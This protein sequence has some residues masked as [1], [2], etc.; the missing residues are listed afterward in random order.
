[1]IKRASGEEHLNLRLT[2]WELGICALV[3]LSGLPLVLLVVEGPW[4]LLLAVLQF[5]VISILSALLIRPKE[6]TLTTSHSYKVIDF[7]VIIT[8]L[9]MHLSVLFFDQT[10]LCCAISSIVVSFV[11]G[12]AIAR[13]L[14]FQW[15]YT[16]IEL[17]VVSYVVSI[18]FSSILTLILLP[19]IQTSILLGRSVITT[20]YLVLGLLPLVYEI[21]KQRPVYQ[22]EI[23]TKIIP[24]EVVALIVIV[25]FFTLSWASTY[26]QM[27]I[28]NSIVGSDV[29]RHLAATL[30]L[31]R[32]PEYYMS[33]YPFFHLY[34]ASLLVIANPSISDFHITLAFLG[35]INILAFFIMAKCYLNKYHK[36]LAAIATMLWVFAAGFGWLFVLAMYLLGVGSYQFILRLAFDY[37]YY[38]VFYGQGL[39]IWVWYRPTTIGFTM[40]FT[41]FYFMRRTDLSKWTSVLLS[42]IIIFGLYFIHLPELIVFGLVLLVTALFVS[43]QE[44]RLQTSSL[45]MLGATPLILISTLLFTLR[46]VPASLS[47]IMLMAYFAASLILSIL[48]QRKWHI[49]VRITRHKIITYGSILLFALFFAGIATWIAFG[50]TFSVASVITTTL[51]P[52]M[53]YPVLLG[54]CGLLSIGAITIIATG[55]QHFKKLVPFIMLLVT[56]PILGHCV[57]L[58]N[59]VFASSGYGERRLVFLTFTGAVM[60]ASITIYKAYTYIHSQSLKGRKAR[61]VDYRPVLA[62]ALVTL[63]V[64]TGCTTSFINVEYWRSR[65]PV[66]ESDEILAIQELYNFISDYPANPIHTVTS[67]SK[68]VL[69]FIPT[70]RIL[71]LPHVWTANFPEIP[72]TFFYDAGLPSPFF[73]LQERDFMAL[74]THYT[75][76]YFNSH[77]KN[78]LTPVISPEFPWLSSPIQGVA[79]SFSSN[80]AL[81]VPFNLTSPVVQYGYDFLSYG[82]KNFT[83]LNELDHR[84]SYF[85]TI[86]IPQD[87]I[88]ESY[89]QQ[90]IDL[91]IGGKKVLVL[92]S[93]G[94]S[95]VAEEF[96]ELITVNLNVSVESPQSTCVLHSLTNYTTP[97]NMLN[98]TALHSPLEFIVDLD[99]R[100]INSTLISEDNQSSIWV[101]EGIGT[102]TTS[103][104]IL[105]DDSTTK[106]T[107]NDSLSITLAE[108]TFGS[109]R[110]TNTMG[111]QDW[112]NYDFLSF[113]WRGIND[114]RV[115]QIEILAPDEN[116]L[117]RYEFRNTW[118]GWRRVVIPIRMPFGTTNIATVSLTKKAMGVPLWETVSAIRVLPN[119][120]TG[121]AFVGDNFFID[122]VSLEGSQTVNLSGNLHLSQQNATLTVSTF[123]G[124]RFIP[125]ITTPW[126]LPFNHTIPNTLYYLDNTK[127][128]D[129]YGSTD[130]GWISLSNAPTNNLTLQLRMP[131]D[132][133]RDWS[134]HDISQ[135]WFRIEP[136]YV[137]IPVNQVES[138]SGTVMLQTQVTAQAFELSEEGVVLSWYSGEGSTRTPFCI[139]RDIGSGQ[140]WFLNTKP[141]VDMISTEPYTTPTLLSKCQDLLELNDVPIINR[142]PVTQIP[143]SYISAESIVFEG[144]ISGFCRSVFLEPNQTIE[145]IRL[146]SSDET[147]NLAKITELKIEG[148]ASVELSMSHASI[149]GGIGYYVAICSD[150]VHLTIEGNDVGISWISESTGPESREQLDNFELELTSDPI[151]LYAHQPSIQ[152][153]GQTMLSECYAYHN[154]GRSL[155]S[156]GNDLYILGDISLDLC[157]ADSFIVAKSF[158]WSGDKILDPPVLE[159][160]DAETFNSI[161]LWTIQLFLIGIC[162]IEIAKGIQQRRRI[163]ARTNRAH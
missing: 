54:L 42:A 68:I 80:T 162:I 85:D 51:V 91:V 148:V 19:L 157:L 82:L 67:D 132:T 74:N 105:S 10:F 149:Q 38:D 128:S 22:S 52:L 47:N 35:F 94:Y 144:D 70:S 93:G 89:M 34:Q 7:L 161:A 96:F 71:S 117:F 159:W 95:L 137:N 147:L 103:V 23:G 151:L 26:L 142:L 13:L 1:M 110:L 158:L 102:G 9:S 6:Y 31:L 145:N 72:L 37:T 76:G 87:I 114:G 77:F 86:V 118:S 156:F 55:E 44:L 92:S 28:F 45:G 60:L 125:I 33:P 27:D 61:R 32:T 79:P 160:N 17:A 99:E 16:I 25:F 49:K 163:T 141:I 116:N 8:V 113:Y 48:T 135:C 59:T 46:A 73:Y 139:R 106:V 66:L 63:V 109:W 3:A 111:L 12:Y 143:R 140:L 65:T 130:I 152:N 18:P 122:H 30:T 40:M 11:P 134:T 64:T 75:T 24:A 2:R 58:Y 78:S 115:Y 14:K 41:L 153:Q 84:L 83:I 15:R 119:S 136:S 21:V 146:V 155:R 120:S 4:K 20:V 98:L 81:V 150:N 108:G 131:I 129:L 90:L 97:Y 138:N 121:D 100:S 5:V 62:V 154:L 43:N 50:I 36:G 56:T 39:S 69:S 127:A 104:P 133:W 124:N 88:S 53:F 57:S 123:D 101:A 107:G 126:H 112:T 29:A